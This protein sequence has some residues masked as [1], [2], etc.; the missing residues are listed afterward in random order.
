MTQNTY[1]L[2]DLKR[3]AQELAD[4]AVEDADRSGDMELQA[5]TKASAARVFAMLYESD[6]P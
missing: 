5:Q 2:R 1:S 4:E 6:K 3:R